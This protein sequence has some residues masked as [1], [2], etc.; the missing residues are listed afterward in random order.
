VTRWPRAKRCTRRVQT[1]STLH[2][3]P[4][5]HQRHACEQSSPEH[6]CSRNVQVRPSMLSYQGLI[7]SY[8]SQVWQGWSTTLLQAKTSRRLHRSRK[9]RLPRTADFR[10]CQPRFLT[11]IRRRYERVRK[12]IRHCM[13][14]G[15]G[16]RR[17]CKAIGPR[18]CILSVS[19]TSPYLSSLHISYAAARRTQKNDR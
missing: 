9:G 14:A 13:A 8:Q 1:S 5:Q 11:S 15:R 16:S 10:L 17:M 7:R 4:L 6:D 19:M 3:P 2:L 12:M 18:T